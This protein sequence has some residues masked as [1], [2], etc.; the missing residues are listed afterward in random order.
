[1]QALPDADRRTD[2]SAS[3][4]WLARDLRLIDSRTMLDTGPPA[5]A[6]QDFNLAASAPC[7]AY[8]GLSQTNRIAIYL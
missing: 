2:Q 8:E 6:L 3:A 5:E 4:A 7:A 1:M